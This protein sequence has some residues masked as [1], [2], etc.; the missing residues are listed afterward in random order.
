MIEDVY[1]KEEEVTQPPQQ[2]NIEF[3]DDSNR[4]MFASN[5]TPDIKMSIQQTQEVKSNTNQR[6]LF[7]LVEHTAP[8]PLNQSHLLPKYMKSKKTHDL[9]MHHLKQNYAKELQNDINCRI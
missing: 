8:Q 7:N 9:I 1:K 2:F 6:I 3:E 4:L 5:Q